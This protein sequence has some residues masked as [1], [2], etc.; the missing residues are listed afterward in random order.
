MVA[1]RQAI[2]QRIAEIIGKEN[3]KTDEPMKNHTSFKIGG[4]AD[5][6]ATPQTD[7]ALSKLLVFCKNEGLPVTVMGN[8]SNLLVMDGG[9]RGVVVKIHENF[10]QCSVEGEKIR[11]GAG[12]LLSRLSATA[13]CHGLSGLEFA[14]GIPGTLGGALF[15]NAGAYGGQMSDVVTRT[16]FMDMD[17]R[18]RS[19]VG[20]EH[21]F[22]YRKSVFQKEQCVILRC[23]LALRSDDRSLI[24]SRMRELNQRRKES[25]P[26]TQPSAGSV[27]K[28][29]EGYYTGK[30]IESCNLK[31]FTIGG[32]QVSGK[33]CG[34]I[35]NT[36][37]ATARDVL[38]VIS[39]IQ[40]Q[41]FEKYGVQLEPEIRIV[42]ED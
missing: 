26:L 18:L 13:A 5:I 19:V 41:V 16:E 28:R 11:A 4:P 34:F 32:A 37:N 33:H 23:E 10:S 25:Q 15:M 35:I 6:F 12:M 31:G 17:G 7:E 24:E 14:S 21:E 3:V 39:H 1:D 42:G 2:A 8:G 30:L 36:G 38:S 20:N 40:K 29:P 27:F 22:G 9:I